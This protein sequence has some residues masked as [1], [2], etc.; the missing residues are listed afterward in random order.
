[1]QMLNGKSERVMELRILRSAR[2]NEPLTMTGRRKVI[3]NRLIGRGLV[4]TVGSRKGTPLVK[5]TRSGTEEL[6]VL[7]GLVGAAVEDFAAK[8]VVRRATEKDG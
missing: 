5:L 1:M 3:L 4:E 8:T 2:V 7:E 6:R